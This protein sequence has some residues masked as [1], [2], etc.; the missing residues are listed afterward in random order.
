MLKLMLIIQLNT[1]GIYFSYSNYNKIINNN[2][3]SVIEKKYQ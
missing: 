2:I 1:K 3:Y